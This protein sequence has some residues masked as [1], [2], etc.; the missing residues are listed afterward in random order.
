MK[1]R[2]I[3]F[4]IF[5]GILSLIRFAEAGHYYNDHRYRAPNRYPNRYHGRGTVVKNY[6]YDY[7]D[8]GVSS[9]QESYFA[10]PKGDYI[11]DHPG[12]CPLDG[13]P[14]IPRGDHY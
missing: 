12:T 8:A 11:S 14:L 9:S 7:P 13:S 5:I 6:Y 4:I 1:I 10:C 3:R 2:Y